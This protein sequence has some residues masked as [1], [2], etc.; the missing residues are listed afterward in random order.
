MKASC[1][2]LILAAAV[3]T[4]EGAPAGD[5]WPQWRGPEGTGVSNDANPPIKWSETENIQWKTE[6]PGHGSSSPIVWED[7]IFILSAQATDKDGAPPSAPPAP[8]RP[9]ARFPTRSRRSMAVTAPK[10]RR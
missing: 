8:K 9:S 10:F 2:A 6:I 1:T 4:T 5:H 7:K 3:L